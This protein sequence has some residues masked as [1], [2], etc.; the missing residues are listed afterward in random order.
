MK[1]AI[2]LLLLCLFFNQSYSQFNLLEEAYKKKSV[3]K[4]ND[5]FDYWQEEIL[6]ISDKE[7]QSLS[8]IEKDVH[9]V[10]CTF[11]NPID[12][13]RIG[14]SEWGDTIYKNVKY[15]IV[16]N[17]L[18]YRVQNKVFFTKEEITAIRN[19]LL[20][21][22]RQQGI[23]SLKL[24][25]IPELEENWDIEELAE[26]DVISRDTI[27]NFRPSISCGDKD[28]VYLSSS[29]NTGLTTFL[30]TRIKKNKERLNYLYYLSD[31]EVTK[32][33]LFLE[34]NIKI[35]RGHWGAYWQ[36]LTYPQVNIMVFDKDR[37]YVK[38]FFRIVYQGGEALLKKEN[39]K[40]NLI[41]S[42]LT[43]IE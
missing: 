9:D 33:Q 26:N 31:K 17:N 11:Y 10:F 32:R 28:V 18:Q 38:V 27:T 15:L 37:E 2:I 3:E 4:L 35:W 13:Q 23:D 29:Y 22:S 14:S 12:L 36:L 1:K 16:Q 21:E 30:G 41:S 20:E 43:W 34:Q 24:Q 6:P 42:K 5:F 39:G 7:Y 25:N 40:W 8:G 19:S